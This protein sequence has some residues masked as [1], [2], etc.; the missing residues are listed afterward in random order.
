MSKVCPQSSK[1]ANDPDY[2]CNPST[3]KWVKKD[4]PTGKAIIEGKFKPEAKPEPKSVPV[5]ILTTE[6]QVNIPSHSEL[7][8]EMAQL[9]RDENLRILETMLTRPREKLNATEG[10]LK[11]AKTDADRQKWEDNKKT[12]QKIISDKEEQIAKIK[13][14]PLTYYNLEERV[15]RAH[16]IKIIFWELKLE[17]IGE[18]LNTSKSYYEM[19]RNKSDESGKKLANKWSDILKGN[20]KAYNDLKK[21]IDDYKIKHANKLK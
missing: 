12:L 15:N 11:S 21:Q 3:G 18:Q 8:T 9:D 14:T 2:I 16:K 4:G 20:E 19:Y 10:L 6:T 17:K 5:P 7:E 1:F 13:S